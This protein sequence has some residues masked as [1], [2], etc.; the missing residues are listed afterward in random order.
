MFDTFIRETKERLQTPLA[1]RLSHL[2]PAVVT[3]FALASGLT[4]GLL[5]IQQLYLLGLF[6]WILNRLLDGFDG[7]LAR[8]NNKQSDFGGYLDILTDFVVYAW[9]P[10]ALVLASPTETNYLALAFLLATF[11]INSAS[12]MHLS[13]ILEKRQH[14]QQAKNK[15]S[16]VVMPNGLIAGSETVVFYC[17][18]I[19]APQ[20]LA[21][22]YLLMGLLVLVTVGQ[23]LVWAH[24]NLK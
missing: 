13:A 10:V 16:T 22:W 15:F 23:R 14:S 5:V 17:L 19:I 20:Q 21:W 18:F 4:A 9:L 2:S 8:V 11:Y 7:T 1:L 24:K 3:L 12:W 6:F